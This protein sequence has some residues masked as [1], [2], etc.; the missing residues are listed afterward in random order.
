M[1]S[2]RDWDNSE[3]SLVSRSSS[4]FVSVASFLL[5]LRVSSDM[6][7]VTVRAWLKPHS[8]PYLLSLAF[9]LHHL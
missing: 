4:E 7:R 3:A 1:S 2:G 6:I 5:T 9:R 8:K